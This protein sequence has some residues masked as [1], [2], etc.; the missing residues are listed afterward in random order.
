MCWQPRP[1]FQMLMEDRLHGTNLMMALV[2]DS[3]TISDTAQLLLTMYDDYETELVPLLIDK[4]RDVEQFDEAVLRVFTACKRAFSWTNTE[5]TE[6][7]VEVRRSTGYCCTSFYIMFTLALPIVF[8][9]QRW[10]VLGLR[11][12][13]YLILPFCS[14][15]HLL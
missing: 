15:A 12:T 10:Y 6:F 2:H 11:P 8:G 1:R 7:V 5:F 14:I 13:H 9:Y 3:W 4:H